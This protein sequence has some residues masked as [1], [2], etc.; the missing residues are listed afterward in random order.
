MS[1]GTRK[2]LA[3]YAEHEAKVLGSILQDQTPPIKH[4]RYCLVIP[5]FQESYQDLSAAWRQLPIDTLI[6]LIINSYFKDDT[7]TI[8]LYDEVNAHSKPQHLIENLHLLIRDKDKDILL[9][10]RCHNDC[11]IPRKQGVGMAR[12]IGADIALALITNG[13]VIE[14]RISLTDADVVLPRDYFT[15]LITRD[16]AALV[17]PFIHRSSDDLVDAIQLY[18]ISMLYYAAGL[19]WS[20][21]HYGFTTIGSLITVNPEHYA[22]VRGFPK[23]DAAEDFYLL[24]KMAKIGAIRSIQ[25][26]IIEIEARLSTRVPFGTGPALAKIAENGIEGYLFYNPMV[27]EELRAF[28]DGFSSLWSASDVRELYQSSPFILHYCETNDFYSTI[29]TCKK[30]IKSQPVFDKFLVDWFDGFRTL[31]FIHEMREHYPS[32]TLEYIADATFVPKHQDPRELRQQLA[33]LCVD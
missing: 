20:G 7:A 3:G 24:N 12:K 5:A 10:D 16:D 2:Y 19:R 4:Y 9:V 27:F 11:L 25:A 15:P 26:P 1:K 32:V 23:R 14:P 28:L 29:E 13:I 31:K 21:S 30:K 18:E 17:Y 22:K 33:A 6:I 8:A